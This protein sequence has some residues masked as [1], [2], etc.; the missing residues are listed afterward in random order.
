MIWV[1]TVTAI[2]EVTYVMPSCW[3]A[4]L[5]GDER[6]DVDEECRL[7]SSSRAVEVGVLFCPNLF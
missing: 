6:H 3:I 1:E 7:C 5:K 2:A 4:S